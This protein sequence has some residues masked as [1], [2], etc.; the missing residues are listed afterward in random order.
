[1]REFTGTMLRLGLGAVAL[2]NV[3]RMLGIFEASPT[4]SALK[5]YA[6]RLA[7]ANVPSAQ[8]V[9]Y[10]ITGLLLLGGLCVLLGV[11]TRAGAFVLALVAVFHLLSGPT[12]EQLEAV[13]RAS[14]VMAQLHFLCLITA[15]SLILHGPGQFALR[16]R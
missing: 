6:D 7:A 9:A 5:E 3:G 10:V 14:R 16:P 2:Y 11:F 12:F 13:G 1:M 8:V 4:T 15:I